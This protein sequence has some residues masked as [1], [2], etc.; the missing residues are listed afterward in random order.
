MTRLYGSSDLFPDDPSNALRP[1]QSVNYITSHDGFT[2]YDLVSFDRRHNEANGHDNTDGANDFSCNHGA[3]GDDKLSSEVLRLRKQQIKNFICLLMLSNGTPMFRMGDEFL[4]TQR[5]NNN[6]YNQDNETSWLD[7]RRLDEHRDIFRFFKEMIA[8]RKAHP[9]LSRSRF[10]R[11]DIRWFGPD[12]PIDLSPSSQA[13]AF[14][15]SGSKVDDADL[16]VLINASRV[17]VTFHVQCGSPSRWRKVIDTSADSP[18][19]I[20]EESGRRSDGSGTLEIA[21]QSVTVLSDRVP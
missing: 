17:P 15:L 14:F 13:L 6:P 1:N 12:G 19:D 4:H 9:T 10:W 20:A 2:L 3:E 18:Q 5:G 8:F 7:W 21:A 16:Y 11:D